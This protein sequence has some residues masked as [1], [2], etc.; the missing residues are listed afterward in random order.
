MTLNFLNVPTES[1]YRQFIPKKQFYSHGDLTT[2]EKN[3]FVNNIERLTLYAQLTRANTNI[4]VYKDDQRT[5]EEVTVFLLELR[6][7]ENLQRIVRT[8]MDTIPYPMILVAKD[9]DSYS[10]YGAHQRDNLV[11]QSKIILEEMYHTD[12]IS[13]DHDFIKQLDYK[14]L[15]KMNFYQLYDNYIQQ[16][17]AHNLEK[18]KIKQVDNQAEVLAAIEEKEEQIQLLRNKLKKEK[19]F[20]KK[21]E[22]N[23]QIKKIEQELKRMEDNDD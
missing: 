23:M 10:F 12:F 9:L 5:Y 1:I 15:N 11:D 14:K 18:R 22:L 4:P 7:K 20:N 16:L 19:H 6:S 17:I 3:L 13:E 8:I 21:M 2:A